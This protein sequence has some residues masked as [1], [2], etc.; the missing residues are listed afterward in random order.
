M[1]T[2]FVGTSGY[3]Y[4]GWTE[5]FY[6][7]EIKKRDWLPYYASRFNTVEINSSF[8]RLP[9]E[10]T[11]ARWRAETPEG[12]VFA[13]KGS[14]YLTHRLRMREPEEP[15]DRLFGRARALGPKLGVVLWQFVDR[16]PQRLERLDAFCQALQAHPV[17]GGVR[18]AFEFRHQSWFVDSTYEV[19]RRYDYALV[20]NQSSVWPEVPIATAS[21]VYA[22]FHGPNQLYASG[23][24]D[25]QLKLWAGRLKSLS[26]SDVFA[27]FN[28]DAY[29]D[30]PYDAEGLYRE[31]IR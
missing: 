19:L 16:F 11:F 15:I 20:I 31:L 10:S 21:W 30:A 29:V 1:K 25:Q 23:Y 28:N 7:A 17:A 13:I 6:P 27:Y 12:F 2:A 14:R 24:S 9:E 4:K 3:Q 18:Q 22:R 8:Y 26:Q 5:K